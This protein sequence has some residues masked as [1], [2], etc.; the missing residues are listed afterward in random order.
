MVRVIAG[1]NSSMCIDKKGFVYFWGN[2]FM[3]LWGRGARVRRS[4]D[5]E[6]A[7]AVSFMNGRH[8]ISYPKRVELFQ[9][10][11]MKEVAMA[12]TTWWCW[13]PR[14]TCTWAATTPPASWVWARAR[15]RW[16]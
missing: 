4:N 2:D 15:R 11:E 3:R 7:S 16:Q 10:L 6:E 1:G 5:S 9:G 13:T 14:V 12:P 8:I